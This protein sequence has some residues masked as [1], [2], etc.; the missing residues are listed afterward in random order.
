MANAQ[1]LKTNF[2]ETQ[3]GVIEHTGM[4]EVELGSGQ[5]ADMIKLTY[6]HAIGRWA[7][8]VL[9]WD[10]VQVGMGSWHTDR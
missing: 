6:V 7:M 4:N 1:N 2:L 3:V 9:G 8:G 5:Q 10:P